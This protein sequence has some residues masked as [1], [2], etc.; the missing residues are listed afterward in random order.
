MAEIKD[1]E[2]K[3]IS[4]LSSELELY[5]ELLKLSQKK[6]DILVKGDVKLALDEITQD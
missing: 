4:V 3:M 1:V 2:N 6:T 5:Q